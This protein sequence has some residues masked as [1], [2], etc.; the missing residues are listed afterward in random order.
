MRVSPAYIKGEKT[1][2]MRSSF[3]PM[4]M[5]DLIC[6]DIASLRGLLEL[7]TEDD[8]D[9]DFWSHHNGLLNHYLMVKK[10]TNL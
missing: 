8:G 7:C 9:P 5:L 10:H 4:G 2:P 3:D 1:T 6:Y